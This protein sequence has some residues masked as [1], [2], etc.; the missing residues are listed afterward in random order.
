MKHP[1]VLMRS[2]PLHPPGSLPSVLLDLRGCTIVEG[3]VR[4]LV[5]AVCLA[6]TLHPRGAKVA[7]LRWVTPLI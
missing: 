1:D 6:L 5:T 2:S 4:F 3:L 7:F